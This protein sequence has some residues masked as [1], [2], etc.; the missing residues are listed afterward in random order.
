M[1]TMGE[2]SSSTWRGRVLI[3]SLTV[4]AIAMIAVVWWYYL[5]QREAT[6]SAAVNQLAAIASVKAAQIAN[7]RHE[8]IGDGR[9]LAVSPLM[10]TAQRI[11]SR[12]QATEADQADVLAVM[13]RL[14]SEFMYADASLV[15]LDGSVLIRLKEARTD[16]SQLKQ[17]SRARLSREVNATG[18]VTLSD[19]SLDTR[20]GRPLME[21]SIPVRDLGALILDIDPSSFL[22]PYLE[23][24]PT[25][26]RTAETLLF[27]REGNELVA[28]S[29]FRHAPG[30]ALVLRSPLPGSNVPGEPE[31]LSGWLHRG[32]DYR[33]VPSLG[34]IHRI[35]DS[36]WYLTAK[37]DVSEVEAPL[38]RLSWEMALIVVLIAAGNGAGVGLIWR[39]EKLQTYRDREELFRSVANDTPAYLWMSSKREENSFI[40][41]P[42]RTL[43]GTDHHRLAGTW[44]SHLHPEDRDRAHDRFLECLTAGC[45][46]LDEFRVRRF[47]GEYRWV[48]ADGVP[49]FSSKGEFEG[50]AGSWLD[51][52]ER[53]EAE[54]RLR[55]VNADLARELRER[56]RTEQEVQALSARLISAQEEERA[57]L[58]RELH[59][60]LSQQ[61]AALSIGMSNLKRQIPQQQVNAHE[62]SDRIHQKLVHVAESIRRLSHE[63]HPAVLEY[64]GLAAAL[65][66]YCSEFELLTGIRV[67][68]QLCGSFESVPSPVSVCIY[69]I[70]QEALQNVAKHANVGEAEVELRRSDGILCLSVSDHGSGIK[71]GRAATPAGLGL[72]SIRERTRL[73]N[74]TF[75]I[76]SKPE[77]GT[78][79]LVTIPA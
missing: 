23:S 25:A 13:S 75:E 24:W 74:G 21:L 51:I 78:T 14:A 38:T 72:V 44:T 47:D 7:W 57:R 2:G 59:D 30:S 66:T 36:L 4:C 22:F 5:R 15:D 54:E 28:L 20:S 49:R 60:D 34:M 73:V 10:R 76:Q 65:R 52:T 53:K 27:R 35:P 58:A 70:T 29:E 40:N 67:S 61:V 6:D 19:L 26:S 56:T 46:Y 43:L 62:Q 31:P 17:R 39:N 16:A 32:P 9:V 11:L 79:V 69:R 45:K 1:L 55:S 18:E 71:S 12:S 68:L 42:L 64:S 3:L 48:I 63:L 37:I 77:Q 33:G 41:K 8:R 50:H